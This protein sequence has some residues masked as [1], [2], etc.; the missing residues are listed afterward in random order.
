[1]LFFNFGYYKFFGFFFYVIDGVVGFNIFND[2]FRG[3]FIVVCI[4][5]V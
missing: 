3:C 1:M 4:D 5:E 2:K